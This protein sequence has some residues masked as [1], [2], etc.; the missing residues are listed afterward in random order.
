LLK[1]AVNLGIGRNELTVNLSS[2]EAESVLLKQI[3]KLKTV[4]QKANL[5]NEKKRKKPVG[6]H[7]MTVRNEDGNFVIMV[8]QPQGRFSADK[9]LKKQVQAWL[10]K[11]DGDAFVASDETAFNV[12]LQEIR[13]KQTT[14]N[15]KFNFKFV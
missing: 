13:N 8:V 14:A 10:G 9:S 2:E 6:T 12:I 3:N 1:E 11:P 15:L 4:I 5:S 7:T